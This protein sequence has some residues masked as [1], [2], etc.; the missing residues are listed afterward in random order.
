MCVCVYRRLPASPL[1]LTPLFS[2]LP[3][4]RPSYGGEQHPEGSEGR[5]GLC[6][7]KLAGKCEPAA[8]QRVWTLL[9]RLRVR[10]LG[11]CRAPLCVPAGGTGLGARPAASRARA[12]CPP[13]P[14]RRPP[15]PRPLFLSPFFLS[16]CQCLN[17]TPQ[18][19]LHGKV[20]PDKA[21]PWGGGDAGAARSSL[22]FSFFLL[23]GCE[24]SV[25]SAPWPAL[26]PSP[27]SIKPLRSE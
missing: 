5:W 22:S 7:I 25:P 2:F 10:G 3:S 15:V 4:P 8:P 6:A 19:R 11:T 12:R 23:G 9:C 26:S 21:R 20:P 24:V 18:A 14:P 16:P 27:K 1:A 17:K 13:S